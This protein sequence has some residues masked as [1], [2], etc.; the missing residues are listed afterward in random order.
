[1]EK[2]NLIFC[3]ILFLLLIMPVVFAVGFTGSSTDE[4]EEDE[5]DEVDD[6]EII[7]EENTGAKITG[8]AIEES[9]LESKGFFEKFI[10]WIKSLFG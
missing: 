8:E 10:D 4:I 6:S 2:R 3:L 1:M 7:L 5:V 9:D